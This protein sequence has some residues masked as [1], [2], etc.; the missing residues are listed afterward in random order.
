MQI[1]WM[2][3]DRGLRR[4]FFILFTAFAFPTNV[5]FASDT[6]GLRFRSHSYRIIYVYFN[7]GSI[8]FDVID[9]WLSITL[10]RTHIVDYC[11]DA[12]KWSKCFLCIILS[13]SVTLGFWM[14]DSYAFSFGTWY[15][16]CTDTKVFILFSYL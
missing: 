1:R 15:K 12:R 14:T 8:E 11:S 16:L 7:F 4:Q 6:Q 5:C 9:D 3:S 2:S 13:P 10:T